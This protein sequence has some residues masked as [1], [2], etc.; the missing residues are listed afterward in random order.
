MKKFNLKKFF[1]YL[2]IA[3]VAFCALL[4]IGVILFGNF[5]EFETRIL[6]TALTLS[7]T[8]ILGLACGAYLE[9]GRG[10]VLPIAGIAC[11]AVSALMWFIVIWKEP[12]SNDIFAQMLMSVTL[13]AAACSH[14]SLLSMAVLDRRFRWSR[15]AAHATVWLLTAYLLYLI[16]L[17]KDFGGDLIPRILGVLSIVLAALT[18]LT[19]VFH[20]LSRTTPKAEEIDAEIARLKARLEELERQKRELA[21]NAPPAEDQT[22]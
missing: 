13:I 8:S 6:L 20:F 5:G 19:P 9:T 2:L 4:G 22:T 18:V 12:T 17:E 16:W 1:L 15:P 7:V 10:R 3:S 11:A 14:L 21:E